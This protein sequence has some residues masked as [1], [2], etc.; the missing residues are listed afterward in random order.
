[1]KR[2]IAVSLIALFVLVGGGLALACTFPGSGDPAGPAVQVPQT[3][4]SSTTSTTPQ[5]PTDQTQPPSS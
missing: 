4:G 1:M 5:V 2:I 3:D